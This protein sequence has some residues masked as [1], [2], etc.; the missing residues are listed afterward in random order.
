MHFV[1]VT[2]DKTDSTVDSSQERYPSIDS[3]LYSFDAIHSQ[4]VIQRF[5][6]HIVY[7]KS[8]IKSRNKIRKKRFCALSSVFAFFRLVNVREKKYT[9]Y[10]IAFM[11]VL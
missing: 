9:R 1:F 3:S 8:Y 4:F 10:F 5:S 7:E 2:S 11:V 6:Q